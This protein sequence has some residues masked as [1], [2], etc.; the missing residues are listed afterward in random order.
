MDY[1]YRNELELKQSKADWFSL[2]PNNWNV[3]MFKRVVESVKN[4]IWGDEPKNDEDDIPC[5]RILNF[6]R[7]EMEINIDDLTTRNIPLLKQKGYLL[8]KGDLLIEK[9]GGGEKNPV[10]FVARYNHDLPA[11]Y[12]NFM[13]KISLKE[14]E[15]KSEY[16]KY[17][18]SN[19]YNKRLHLDAVHQTTGIQNLD[20]ETYF[21]RIIPLPSIAEQEKI[22]KF[23]DEK[24]SEFDSIISKKEALI[25]K[26]EEAKKSLISE[27]VTGKVKVVKTDEGYE[28][29]ER[30]KEEMKDSGVEWVK[31]IPNEWNL[32]RSNYVFKF[33]KGL[34]I[35]KE[36]LQDE[37][38]P[39]INYGEI[40]SKYGFEVNPKKH[41][42]KCVSKEY[43]KSNS[44]AL[45]KYGDFIFADTSEDIKGCGNFSYLNSEDR[46]FAGYHTVIARTLEN[47]SSRYLAYL[48]DS[49][50]WRSQ[51]RTKVSG[52]KVFSITQSILKKTEVILPIL[53]EQK[54]IVDYL[55]NKFLSIDSMI[56]SMK[57]QIEKLKEA[58]QSLISEAVTGKIEILE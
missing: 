2:I 55:D 18:C 9:S 37:G 42:L 34:S 20:T 58:K 43:I 41:K 3:L 1:R 12:A 7:N 25:Q 40:H 38:I 33:S 17:L 35:T 19:I 51:I 50:D 36:N 46:I 49:D 54:L 27:V 13:A 8:K 45:I 26:L 22:A 4:G 48:F 6:N 32:K 11:V 39:C 28:L 31:L 57:R 21:K 14:N 5:I 56:N 23:L 15:A 29:V 53:E 10:G 24:T 47:I 44:N 52:I 30:K 16:I